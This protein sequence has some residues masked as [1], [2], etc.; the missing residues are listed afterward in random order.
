[1]N[2]LLIL[3]LSSILISL[4]LW[5]CFFAKMRKRNLQLK[6]KLISTL[7]YQSKKSRKSIIFSKISPLLENKEFAKK[8]ELNLESAGLEISFADYLGFHFVFLVALG[9]LLYFLTH[10]LFLSISGGLLSLILPSIILKQM[11]GRKIKKIEKQLPHFL[12]LLQ[13]AIR[14]G[15]SLQQSLEEACK[16]IPQPLKK[17]LQILIKKLQVGSIIEQALLDF[18]HQ[19]S[20]PD[21]EMIVTAFL[22]QRQTGGDLNLILD[23]LYRTISQR[24]NL[25]YEIKAL[26]AQAR[27]SGLIIALLPMGFFMFMSLTSP[28]NIAALFSQ[29]RGFLIF[30]S[31]LIMNLAGLFLMRRITHFK[32]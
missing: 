26:T 32:E 2:E 28:T 20:S 4:S 7:S 5:I 12:I 25:K 21:M 31:A 9:F 1:M 27:L 8:I 19:L 3:I 14:A 16:R 15:F 22:I 13:N 6:N 30:I 10:S 18:S 24:I 17:E 29:S 11:K 23:S